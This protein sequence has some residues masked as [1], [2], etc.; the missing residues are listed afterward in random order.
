M[1]D[2]LDH[3]PDD[4]ARRRPAPCVADARCD[5]H[6]RMSSADSNGHPPAPK[7]RGSSG[8]ASDDIAG[9]M[10]GHDVEVEDEEE[11]PPL[12][13][14]LDVAFTKIEWDA[15]TRDTDGKSGADVI[16]EFV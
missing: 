2:A 9:Y 7:R 6:D 8:I 12:P 14:A 11:A 13:A 4:R 15:S 1:G 16:N 10:P 3:R 5:R